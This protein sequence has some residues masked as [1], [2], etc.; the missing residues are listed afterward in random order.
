[1]QGK[2]YTHWMPLYIEKKHFDRCHQ[3]KDYSKHFKEIVKDLMQ[4]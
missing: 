4:N 1:M 2:N 3:A